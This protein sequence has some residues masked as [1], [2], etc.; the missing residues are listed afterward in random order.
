MTFNDIVSSQL[1]PELPICIERDAFSMDHIYKEYTIR[2]NV[3][4]KKRPAV[5]IK[6]IELNIVNN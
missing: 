1:F 2:I 5:N 4:E 6:S 3:Q